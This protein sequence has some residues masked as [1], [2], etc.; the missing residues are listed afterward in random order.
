MIILSELI[1]IAIYTYHIIFQPGC[2]LIPALNGVAQALFWAFYI[3][4]T[5]FLPVVLIVK[6]CWTDKNED[7]YSALAYQ[8]MKLTFFGSLDNFVLV[9]VSRMILMKRVTQEPNPRE[10]SPLK[11]HHLMETLR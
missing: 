3:L 7:L 6:C 11:C 8:V 9:F 10:R 5:Y 1:N 4:S 2:G